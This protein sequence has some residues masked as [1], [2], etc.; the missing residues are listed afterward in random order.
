MLQIFS[1]ITP[2]SHNSWY[3]IAQHESQQY[4]VSSALW[5]MLSLAV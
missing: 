1:M 4:T 5:I 3:T 2:N